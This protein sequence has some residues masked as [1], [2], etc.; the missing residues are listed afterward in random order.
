MTVIRWQNFLPCQPL[1]EKTHNNLG[2]YFFRFY[3]ENTKHSGNLSNGHLIMAAINSSCLLTRK[4]EQSFDFGQISAGDIIVTA[5]C[6]ELTWQVTGNATFIGAFLSMRYIHQIA[7]S[8]NLAS[9]KE[10]IIQKPFQHKDR[11]ITSLFEAINEHL[12]SPGYE[13]HIYTEA[14][15]RALCIHLLH[16][17]QTAVAA[18]LTAGKRIFS[19][20]QIEKIQTYIDERIEQRILS[21][22]LAKCVYVSDYHFYRI[23][24]RTTGLTPQRFIKKRR[25]EVAREM[26]E[27]S[28]ATLAAIA[29]KAGFVDQSHMAREFRKAFGATPSQLRVLQ[30]HERNFSLPLIVEKSSPVLM[31]SSLL[32]D[33]SLG[34]LDYFPIQLMV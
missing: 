14:M 28:V 30:D 20:E 8:L 34:L 33:I 24:K 17:S 25:L 15:S 2:V 3:A 9:H 12:S 32:Q 19:C 10:I 22:E 1:A 11:L 27:N 5:P 29:Y 4:T 13:D 31:I 7:R 26:V 18:Q 6:E 16:A 23:F 21:C